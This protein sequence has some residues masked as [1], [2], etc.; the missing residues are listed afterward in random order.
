MAAGATFTLAGAGSGQ[1]SV[2]ATAFFTGYRRT[3]LAPHEVLVKVRRGARVRMQGRCAGW[4]WCLAGHH[5]HQQAPHE[6]LVQARS[7]GRE[8]GWVACAA[9]RQQA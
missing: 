7:G 2:P 9:A 3:A 1:R 8:G 5:A 6:V 4:R